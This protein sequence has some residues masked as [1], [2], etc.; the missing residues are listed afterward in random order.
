MR[1]FLIILFVSTFF[2]QTSFGQTTDDEKY[3]QASSYYEAKEYEKALPILKELADKNLAK[4]LNLLGVLYN[5]GYSVPKNM[6]KAVELYQKSANLGWR[7]AQRNIGICYEEGE[8][9]PKNLE[10]AYSWYEKAFRQYKESADKGDAD[11][12]LEVGIFYYLG[13]MR[14]GKNYSKA[15][16]WFEKSANQGNADATNYLGVM[17][18][19]A[20]GVEKDVNKAYNYYLKGAE[21]G[22]CYAQRNLAWLFQDEQFGELHSSGE[23][24][25]FHEDFDFDRQTEKWLRMAAQNNTD[26]MYELARFYLDMQA[27]TEWQHKDPELYLKKA[28]DEGSAK[29]EACIGYNYMI[30]NKFNE[31]IELLRLSKQNGGS[32][33]D[34]FEYSESREL[35]VDL[36]LSICQFFKNNPKYKFKEAFTQNDNTLVIAENE[37]KKEGL[38]LFSRE[39]NIIT[40]TPFEFYDLYFDY[41]SHK[42]S[43]SEKETTEWNDRKEILYLCPYL[44]IDILNTLLQY[45]RQHIDYSFNK[46]IYTG[47]DHLY[48][49]AKHKDEESYVKITKGEVLKTTPFTKSFDFRFEDYYDEKEE[50][51]LRYIMISSCFDKYYPSD[52]NYNYHSCDF[53]YIG[54]TFDLDLIFLLFGFFDK[55]SEYRFIEGLCNDNDI[56]LSVKDD[57]NRFCWLRISGAGQILA[58]TPLQERQYVFNNDKRCF[59]FYDRRMEKYNYIKMSEMMS[60]FK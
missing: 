5:Y 16:L 21:K 40:R 55:H 60:L 30:E 37:V 51:K 7:G 26:Y 53:Y 39:G 6:Q 29:A 20:Y 57:Q 33:F 15:L 4:A 42:L 1:K 35:S 24:E 54:S 3:E 2:V 49:I 43:Y 58:K 11:A 23:G 31:A 22:N 13:R 28:A 14:S 10:K 25:S 46:A 19:Y 48:V 32:V 44:N 52:I 18:Q 38:L 27:S 17:Y 59:A 47:K 36:L 9:V 56:L 12:Q 8:G 45:F 34:S 50:W 41:S